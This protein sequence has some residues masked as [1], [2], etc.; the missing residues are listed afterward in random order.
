LKARRERMS[1]GSALQRRFE[2]A[3]EV[4]ARRVAGEYLLVPIRRRAGRLDC[5]FT[6]DEVGAEI[7]DSIDGARDVGQLVE[8]VLRDFEVEREEAARD[9]L[10]FVEGLREAGVIREAR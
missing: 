8:I 7:W 4:V 10:D 6:L 5:I 2:K 1:D 3:P 9:V